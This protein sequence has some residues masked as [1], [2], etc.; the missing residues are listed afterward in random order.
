MDIADMV[1][2]FF[3]NINIL[4]KGNVN[5]QTKEIKESIK[6]MALSLKVILDYIGAEKIPHDFYKYIKYWCNLNIDEPQYFGTDKTCYGGLYAVIKQI[7]LCNDLSIDEYNAFLTWYD[8]RSGGA[9]KAYFTITKHSNIKPF[10]SRKETIPYD[11]IF[12]FEEK[13]YNN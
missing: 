5:N 12:S 10:T 8:A 13:D 6:G 1:Q 11:K 4:I 3:N 9:G 2:T 7:D